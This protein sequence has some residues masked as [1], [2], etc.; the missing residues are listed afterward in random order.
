MSQGQIKCLFSFLRSNGLYHFLEAKKQHSFPHFILHMYSYVAELLFGFLPPIYPSFLVPYPLF[1][2]L[3]PLGHQ[4]RHQSERMRG[5]MS[6]HGTVAAGR[7]T[8][9]AM[10]EPCAWSLP[11]KGVTL[12][13][14]NRFCP[15]NSSASF[16]FFLCLLFCFPTL[17]MKME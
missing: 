2:D 6:P 17:S 8:S 15:L 16:I 9:Q 7:G 11:H 5:G 4:G 14:S 10:A 12:C 13:Y 3:Q 1:N